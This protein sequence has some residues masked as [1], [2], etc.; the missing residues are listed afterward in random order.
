MKAKHG[1]RGAFLLVNAAR[2]S[3]LARYTACSQLAS[4]LALARL[5]FAAAR[6]GGADAVRG[7]FDFVHALEGEE[8]LHQ[9][10]WRLLAASGESLGPRRR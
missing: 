4:F 9:E 3:S 8:Q 6:S 10:H 5:P 2:R 7:D 1:Q